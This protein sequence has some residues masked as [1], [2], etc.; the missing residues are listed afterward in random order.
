VLVI[1]SRGKRIYS[2]RRLYDEARARGAKVRVLSP[3]ACKILLGCGDSPGTGTSRLQP[4]FPE[5]DRSRST[6]P[7]AGGAHSVVR[8]TRAVRPG[9]RGGAVI[10]RIGASVTDFGLALLTQF[11]MLGFRVLNRAGAFH[12]AR[13]KLLA[14]QT[15]SAAGIRVPRTVMSRDRTD[16]DAMV[17]RVGGF[18]LVLKLTTGTQGVGVMIAES[19]EAMRSALDALWG[20]GQNILIQQYVREAAGRDVRVV[21]VGGLPVA[22]YRRIAR[23]GD[24]RSNLHRGGKGESVMPSGDLAAVAVASASALGLDVAGVDILESDEGP[25]VMEVNAS[26]GLRGAEKFAGV[27]VAGAIVNLAL[28]G[29]AEKGGTT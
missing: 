5:P 15:L 11:E 29:S 24:F 18:P 21:V 1:I 22:A 25:M 2:T 9:R 13:N 3:F 14:L 20:L 7:L 10:P 17:D 27:N 23:T 12:L 4:G 8:G 28:E 26:P 19:M 16:L 6:H